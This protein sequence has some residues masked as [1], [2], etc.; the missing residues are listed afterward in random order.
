MQSIRQMQARRAI[1]RRTTHRLA[2]L[3]GLDPA[4][5]IIW[6]FGNG[7]QSYG[8]WT[9]A[10]V[11]GDTGEV[12][13]LHWRAAA[14]RE[15]MYTQAKAAVEEK[16][17]TDPSLA[18]RDPTAVAAPARVS[19]N[20]P[21]LRLSRRVCSNYKFVFY[22]V[23][24]GIVFVAA[25]QYL[26]VKAMLSFNTRQRLN[27]MEAY[28]VAL[29]AAL[30]PISEDS[31]GGGVLGVDAEGDW[32]QWLQ[33]RSAAENMQASVVNA[34]VALGYDKELA[35]RDAAREARER[36]ERQ[37]REAVRMRHATYWSL[38]AWVA[39]IVVMLVGFFM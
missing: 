13:P 1:W 5:N 10:L 8:G 22:A 29:L 19:V 4:G 34:A 38:T 26:R 2:G 18:E 23:W 3:V 28:A 9:S 30:V 39:S 36:E 24:S 20:D 35:A 15:D 31:T 14:T 7:R 25:C 32:L 17:R 27:A 16:L 33:L 37:R 12:L 21:R 6:R 11:A